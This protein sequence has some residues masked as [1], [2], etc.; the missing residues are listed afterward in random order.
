MWIYDCK[1]YLSAVILKSLMWWKVCWNLCRMKINTNCPR[2]SRTIQE[3]RSQIN[4][5]TL[6]V[7]ELKDMPDVGNPKF[8][9]IKSEPSEIT[10]VLYYQYLYYAFTVL[11]NSDAHNQRYSPPTPAICQKRN[12]LFSA[13]R[14]AT[15][16]DF[17]ILN[18]KFLA[19]THWA[20]LASLQ[21]SEKFLHIWKFS[22]WGTRVL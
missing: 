5:N 8:G 15:H 22:K 19:E 3:S 13:K 18:C 11:S 21:F 4:S 16:T 9:Y 2:S 7:L 10:T 14:P 6:W 1:N 17:T 12:Q 20:S